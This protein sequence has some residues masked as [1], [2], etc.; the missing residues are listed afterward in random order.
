MQSKA[1]DLI[2]WAWLWTSHGSSACLFH[3]LIN[4]VFFG[5]VNGEVSV[6]GGKIFLRIHQCRTHGS[7]RVRTVLLPVHRTCCEPRSTGHQ[8]TLQW[9]ARAASPQPVQ[10]FRKIYSETARNKFYCHSLTNQSLNIIPSSI[11]THQLLG[12]AGRWA[13]FYF[14]LDRGFSEEAQTTLPPP[15]FPGDHLEV[16]ETE[17][18]SKAHQH[19]PGLPRGLPLAQDT[20]TGGSVGCQNTDYHLSHVYLWSYSVNVTYKVSVLLTG[21]SLSRAGL[22]DGQPSKRRKRTVRTAERR[23]E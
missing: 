13:L 20:S 6:D 18:S 14:P 11:F 17:G 2:Y 7:M 21:G 4:Q 9:P 19:V 15:A 10:I 16:P 8:R 3:K 1:S 22:M 23:E 5:K 12:W